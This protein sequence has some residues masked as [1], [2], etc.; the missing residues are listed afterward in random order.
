MAKVKYWQSKNVHCLKSYFDLGFWYCL[1]SYTNYTC[2]F[3]LDIF[4]NFWSKLI[5]PWPDFF[6]ETSFGKLSASWFS[7]ICLHGRNLQNS[8]RNTRL[9]RLTLELVFFFFEF[10]FSVLFLELDIFLNFWSKLIFPWPD[11]FFETSFGKLSASWFSAICL[12]GRNSQNSLRNTRLS[13]LTLE[14]VFFFFEF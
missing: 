1:T 13:R 11:F 5:F 2:W 8:W 14:L 7:A 12:H 4:L 6:F 10:N 9:S 3:E